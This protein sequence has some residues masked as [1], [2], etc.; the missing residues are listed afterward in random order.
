[1]ARSYHTMAIMPL[2]APSCN[3]QTQ[4]DQVEEREMTSRVTEMSAASASEMI[5]YYSHRLSRETDCY[6]VFE[7]MS[8][9]KMDFVLVDVRSEEKYVQ[10]HV[11]GA[12]HML[13][14]K[15]TRSRL[16]AWPMETLFVVYC[17]GPHC[18]GTDKA[19]L[20]LAELGRKVKVMIGGMTGWADE[21]YAFAQGNLPGVVT[22][23]ES[24]A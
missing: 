18:N 3:A 8:S 14:G 13:V 10:S 11:P 2:A 15:M 6:D 5:A 4:R 19:A 1:M 17:A 24:A 21:G 20:K 7:S 16:E 22:S 12:I 23:Y 9:G